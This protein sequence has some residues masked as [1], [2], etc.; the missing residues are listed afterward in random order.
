[1]FAD[2]CMYGCIKTWVRVLMNTCNCCKIL[3]AQIRSLAVANVKHIILVLQC[4]FP[5]V[6]TDWATCRWLACI[7]SAALCWPLINLTHPVCVACLFLA[8]V[9]SFIPN[10]GCK[11][12]IHPSILFVL[13]VHKLQ[14]AMKWFYEHVVYT[15][16]QDAHCITHV[17]YFAL[18]YLWN[19]SLSTCVHNVDK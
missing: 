1:M 16:K 10:K 15:V 11:Q 5:D 14:D 8:K 17:Q 9:Q 3:Y 19:L 7:C 13:Q 12:K 18:E 6:L 4:Y 2:S